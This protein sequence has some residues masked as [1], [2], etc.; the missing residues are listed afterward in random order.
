MLPHQMLHP[1][2]ASRLKSFDAKLATATELRD[3]TTLCAAIAHEELTISREKCKQAA[4]AKRAAR[5]AVLRQHRIAGGNVPASRRSLPYSANK[6]GG[7]GTTAD[8]SVCGQPRKGTH[9]KLTTDCPTLGYKRH[10]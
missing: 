10:A 8:C 4:K 2:N 7:R 3:A 9:G 5:M 6:R 1:T